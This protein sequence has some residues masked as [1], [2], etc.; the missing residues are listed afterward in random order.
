[1]AGKSDVVLENFRAARAA[2][3]GLSSTELLAANP[4]LIICSISGYGRTGTVERPAGIRLRRP[5]AQRLD[6]RHRPRRRR[7]EQGRRGGDGRANGAVRGG[8][9]IGL[10]SR[11]AAPAA[12]ATS[13]TWLYWICR[14]RLRSI[15][16]QAFLSSGQTPPRQGNAHLQI[17][18][19]QL[20]A[21]VDSWM[22][23]AIG[24]DGQWRRFL[25][26]GRPQRDGKNDERFIDDPTP[27]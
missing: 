4:R 14:W 5:G 24:N 3:L 7:T 6:E 13:S 12:M 2:K 10:P 9:G 25:Q 20:F 1:M 16:A 22:V 17:V 15:L 27:V 26:S 23:L 19:Y 11:T 21:T 18:P 8:R